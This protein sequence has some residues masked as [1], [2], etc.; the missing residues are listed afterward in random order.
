MYYKIDFKGDYY[1]D[2]VNIDNPAYNQIIN[3][4][5]VSNFLFD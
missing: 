3:L 5:V 1:E 2:K 4:S